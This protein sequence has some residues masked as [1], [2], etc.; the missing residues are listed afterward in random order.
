MPGKMISSI[1]GLYTRDTSSTST[2]SC[3]NHKYHQE[4]VERLR[5]GERDEEV[6]HR[7]FLEQ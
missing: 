1:P 5:G 4:S 7:G 3:D 6:E 2:P